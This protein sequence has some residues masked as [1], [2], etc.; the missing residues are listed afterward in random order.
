MNT[1]PKANWLFEP[2]T[3][4]QANA[5]VATAWTAI[6]VVVAA[7]V[8]GLIFA[9]LVTIVAAVLLGAIAWQWWTNSDRDTERLERETED[10]RAAR[11]H[12]ANPTD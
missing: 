8:A 7:L 2:R 9:P 5:S 3:A 6:T 12:W 1:E 10:R 11:A 4:L